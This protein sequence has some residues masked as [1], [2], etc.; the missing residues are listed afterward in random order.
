MMTNVTDIPD[1][2]PTIL[3]RKKCLKPSSMMV[4][5]HTWATIESYA[6][7]FNKEIL[8][9]FIHRSTATKELGG[10][11]IDFFNL[12]EPL[13]NC[14]QIVPMYFQKIPASKPLILKTLI[15]EVQRLRD[16]VN[17]F[18]KEKMAANDFSFLDTITKPCSSHSKQLHYTSSSS[19]EIKSDV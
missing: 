18:S 11:D 6:Y 19:Q 15:L 10:R 5:N 4:D 12:P 16:E 1:H 3:D 13:A 14:K 7:E 9:P 8:P 2:L 17:K